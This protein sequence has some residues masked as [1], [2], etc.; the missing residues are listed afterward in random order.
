M[1][2][3]V[4]SDVSSHMRGGVPTETR[5]LLQGLAARGHTLALAADAPL[6][7]A[8]L[9]HFALALPS[10]A[11]WGSR[12]AEIV[13]GFRPDLVH[14]MAMGSRGLAAIAPVLR[15]QRWVLTIHSVPPHERKLAHCHGSETL[16]YALRS[17]RFAANS[18]A[19][20]WLLRR[21]QIP[22]VVVHSRFVQRTVERYGYPGEVAL[23]PLGFEPGT[24]AAARPANMRPVGN[25]PRL[26][27][28]AGLAHTKGQHDAVLAMAAIK[29]QFPG[30][31]LQL[32]GE[33]RDG[34]YLAFL[35]ELIERHGLHGQ[36]RIT[37]N[38]DDASKQQALREADFYLQ[39]SHEEGFCLAYIEAAAIVPRLVGADT[40]AIAAMSAGDAGARVVAP[41]AP[42]AIA[43]AVRELAAAS[44]PADLLGA[45]SARL[46]ARFS[47]SAYLDAHERLYEDLRT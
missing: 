32:I 35:N 43:A 8:A 18:T 9:Q 46:V 38:L 11:P 20:K 45:R 17:L 44:L 7:G 15:G 27:T 47:W 10:G 31:R 24:P 21:S 13:Q 39:P 41:R 36:I 4:L 42:A 34:S 28:V 2:I 14:V 1:R 22:R 23:V 25:S 37:P 29:D 16:H 30:L 26:V 3:L 6:G 12:L 19:W 33:V 5:Q 40:G